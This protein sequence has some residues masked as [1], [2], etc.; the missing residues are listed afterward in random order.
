V[1][2]GQLDG[3]AK[4]VRQR[5]GQAGAS[6]EAKQGGMSGA[7]PE[8]GD[9][10]PAVVFDQELALVANPGWVQGAPT[11]QHG[12]GIKPG[13]GGWRGHR[14]RPQPQL[15]HVGLLLAC[16]LRVLLPP[17]LRL[18]VWT[19]HGGRPGRARQ[20]APYRED[21]DSYLE[22]TSWQRRVELAAT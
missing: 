13:C 6:G 2:V 19:D 15:P 16:A 14:G 18:M 5:L 21:A 3:H 9:A 10:R 12:Q 20:I 17:A 7:R 1:G 11:A 8:Q 22:S 4:G